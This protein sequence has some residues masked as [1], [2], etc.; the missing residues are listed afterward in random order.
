MI[1]LSTMLFGVLLA[2]VAHAGTVS[3]AA[4][5]V[6]ASQP[7]LVREVDAVRALPTRAGHVRLVG[8][9]DDPRAGALF[10]ERALHEAELDGALRRA[11]ARTGAS[12]TDDADL[13]RAFLDEAPA[14]LRGAALAG[15]SGRT[16]RPGAEILAERLTDPDASVREIAVSLL[17]RGPHAEAFVGPLAGRLSDPSP[18]VRRLAA[19]AVGWHGSSAQVPVLERA[20][21]DA[22]GE[23]RLTALRALERLDP[24]AAVRVSDSLIRDE[25]PG[26]VRAAEQIRSTATP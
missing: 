20:T 2:G 25:H 13:L 8:A 12:L 6:G 24:A 17:S 16:W 4:E 3:T 15:M 1:R 26:V 9:P 10:L 7:E 14:D 11:H 21:A 18:T 19:R 23:V 22:D 5:Q